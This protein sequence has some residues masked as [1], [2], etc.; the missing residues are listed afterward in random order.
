MKTT[1]MNQTLV[2]YKRKL[3]IIIAFLCIGVFPLTA[4][5]LPQALPEEV[6][7]QGQKLKEAAFKVNQLIDQEK[8]AGAVLMVAKNGRIVQHKPLGYSDVETE[9]PMQKDDLFRIYSMTKPITSVAIMI[10]HDRGKIRLDAPISTYLPTM[11]GL[12]L[13]GQKKG[14]LS[15]KEMTI[16]DLL[17]HTSGLTYGFFSNTAVDRKYMRNHPLFS[18][19][20]EQFIDKLS[21]LPLLHRPGKT[22]HYSVSTDV[23]GAVVEQVSGQTLGEFFKKEIF[24]PLQMN[25]THFSI[26]E[27]KVDRFTTS[28]NHSMKVKDAYDASEFANP[29]RMQS[30]G[31]GLISTASDYMRFCLMLLNKGTLY[32]SRILKSRTVEM[33]TKNQ[34][35]KGVY[36]DGYG[37]FG[38]G[39]RIQI[40]DWG[41]QGHL[42]EYGWSGAAS[43]HFWISPRDQLVVIVLSQREPFTNQL[44]DLL[45][46]VYYEALLR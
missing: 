7:V 44:Q 10:L 19:D 41:G 33:M 23:L 31:G 30:G 20:N 42:D 11:K 32:G 27:S 39:F 29:N 35:P 13:H 43:T 46:P 5:Q 3:L 12:K 4:Q 45:K 8:I 36:T 26:S 2:S 37:G 1:K 9:R 16:R 6:G 14:S 17:R 21:V 34:L 18:T 24:D 22:F 40:Q 15:P 28:Y 38:L 25:D